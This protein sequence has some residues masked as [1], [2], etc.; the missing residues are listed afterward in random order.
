[1]K[2]NRLEERLSSLLR[3]G[4]KGIAPYVTAGDGGL[5]STLAALR[6]LDQVGATCVEL[7]LPFSDPIADGPVLQAAAE[8]ALAAGTRFDGLLDVVRTLRSGDH[9]APASEMPVVLFS[10]ANPLLARGWD[11]AAR[12]L[13][14]AGV[15][16]WLVP[17]LPLEESADMRAAAEEHGL[18]PIFF[19]APTT[20][21]ERV[22]AAM[23]ASRGFLYAIGRVGVTG[24]STVFDQTA[25]DFVKR[26]RT[27]GELPIAV[28]FGLSA[29]RH[30][31]PALENADLAIVGSALVHHLHLARDVTR[32]EPDSPAHLARVTAAA[33]RVFYRHLA[34]GLPGP[35]GGTP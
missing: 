6:G 20:S 28:G 16:G 24:A 17:D 8:R 14:A 29:P 5:E 9:S 4:G 7:G 19:V 11:A 30:I 34:E 1:M 27:A 25:V 2:A 35:P 18:C 31:R 10:Y 13:A 21:P 3:T 15:D 12:D 26:L 23:Q 22:R 32:P 33:A